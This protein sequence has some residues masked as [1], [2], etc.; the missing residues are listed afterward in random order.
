MSDDHETRHRAQPQEAEPGLSPKRGDQQPQCCWKQGG[1]VHLAVLPAPHQAHQICREQIGRAGKQGNVPGDA[2]RACRQVH[3]YPGE[4]HV[5]D[6][7]PRQG[8]GHRQQ[9][10]QD[11][12][13]IEK[14]SAS[15]FDGGNTGEEIWIPQR[16]PAE[17]ADMLYEERAEHDPGCYGILAQQHVAFGADQIIA[18]DQKSESSHNDEREPTRHRVQLSS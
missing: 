12:G 5:E 2:E 3:E 6:E 11:R 16:H 14:I 17:R 18:E 9:E 7:L 15:C 10:V 8:A 13:G 1:D 4:V